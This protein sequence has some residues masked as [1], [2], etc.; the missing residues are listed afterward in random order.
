[1]T[2]KN[3]CQEVLGEMRARQEAAKKDFLERA[4]SIIKKSPAERKEE[5]L[6]KQENLNKNEEH[7]NNTSKKIETHNLCMARSI[8]AGDFRVMDL[9]K[10]EVIVKPFL[11]E[12]ELGQLYAARGC[13]KTMVSMQFAVA[14]TSGTSFLCFEVPKPKRVA[15]IDGE[16][17][18]SFLRN[19]VNMAINSLQQVNEKNVNDN[20]S[21][22]TPDLQEKGM[23]NIA[24]EA[25]RAWISNVIEQNDVII[26]DSLLTLMPVQRMNDA[27]SFLPIKTMLFEDIRN[28]G[29]SAIFLHHCGKNG[30]QLGTITKEIFV[31]FSI[32]LD[33]I[34]EGENSHDLD[35]KLS[36]DKNRS[37]FGKDA[38][39]V[40]LR[41]D[42]GVWSYEKCKDWEAQKILEMYEN[43]LTQQAIA[44]ELRISQSSVSRLLKKNGVSPKR[45][46]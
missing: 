4:E 38:E 12:R 44:E 19:R 16:T 11:R 41:L 30:T 43:G 14:I 3:I 27:D 22:V 32:R 15:F 26:F 9:P 20:L 7:C 5:T 33:H 17:P 31:D 29:K 24:T 21:L 35:L 39:P 1:M 10:Q 25:G 45:N 8:K 23:L 36:Y 2:S 37:F 40:I 46:R 13:G 18:A 34:D 6:Q 28:K 42:N